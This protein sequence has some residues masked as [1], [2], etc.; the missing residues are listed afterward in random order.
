MEKISSDYQAVAEL[1]CE[2]TRNCNIKEDL[3][4]ASFNLSPTE[5]RLLKL[6]VLTD[7]YSIK[8]IRERLNLTSGRVS[9]IL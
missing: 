4:A 7:T 1:I 2:L 5:V 8:E 3:F 6:F 9:H